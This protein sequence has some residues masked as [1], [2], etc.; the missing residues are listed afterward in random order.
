MNFLSN[1]SDSKA[2]SKT[3]SQKKL[4]FE[5][6][7]SFYTLYKAKFPCTYRQVAEQRV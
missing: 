7:M 4:D 3:F 2:E 1:A 5:H 6:Q